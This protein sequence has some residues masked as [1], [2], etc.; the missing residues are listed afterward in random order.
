MYG[1]ETMGLTGRQ[2]PDLMAK[3]RMV[4]LAMGVTRI[5]RIRN[6]TLGNSRF[7]KDWS[8]AERV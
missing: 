5:G 2:G 6:E 3:L 7:G 8:E 4:R 1:L